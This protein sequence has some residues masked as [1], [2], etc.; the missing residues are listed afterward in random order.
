[1]IRMVYL[2]GPVLSGRTEQELQDGL[3]EVVSLHRALHDLN[4]VGIR[5]VL[6]WLDGR[7]ELVSRSDAVLTYGDWFD[8]PEVRHEVGAALA[9]GKPVFDDVHALAQWMAGLRG[10]DETRGR[11][12]KSL[13][14]VRRSGRR[15]PDRHH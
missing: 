12:S 9:M 11:I 10:D 5:P 3:E 13:S 8:A 2:A 1:M 15:P 6:P 14:E 7:V 4:A